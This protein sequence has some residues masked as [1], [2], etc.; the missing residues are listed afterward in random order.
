M[1]PPGREEARWLRQQQQ[2][3]SPRIVDLLNH[4]QEILVQVAKAP[5]GT[6][7][8]RITTHIALPGRLLVFL[9]TVDHVGVSRRIENEGERRRLREMV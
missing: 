2:A 6:K 5:I 3:A 4:G 8:A 1:C 7:G 9:P